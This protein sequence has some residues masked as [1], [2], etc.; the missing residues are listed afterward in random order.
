MN[1]IILSS[2]LFG[3][4]HP[5]S[6]IILGQ[7]IELIDFCLLYVGLR[8]IFQTPFFIKNS[9]LTSN[10]KSYPWGL[11]VLFGFVGAALQLSEFFGLSKGL[12][13]ATVTFLVY[14]HP[15]WS[16]IL[17]YFINKEKIGANEVIRVFI[18]IA[19]IYF[20][21]A[22]AIESGIPFDLRIIAPIF[23]GFLI[24]LWSSL[25]NKLRKLGLA[26]LDV[27]F[28]Y[29]L[30]A[31]CSLLLLA[32]YDSSIQVHA[33][34]IYKWL[35]IIPNI[36]SISFYSIAIGL[37]PNFLFYLGSGRSS[38]LN[39]SLLLLIEPV[40]ATI[41]AFLHMS[42]S[43]SS[44]FFAGALFV[45]LS[46]LPFI[47]LYSLLNK[48]FTKLVKL[49]LFIL[50]ILFF[51]PLLLF[52][53]KLYLVE[54]SPQNQMEY[55]ISEELRLIETS[56][57]MSIQK[58]KQIFPKCKL[59]VV[60]HLELGSEE[61]LFKYANSIEGSNEQVAIV[62][63]SRSTFARIGA[64]ALQGRNILGISIG[65]TAAHFNELNPNF[66]SVVSP[67]KSQVEAIKRESLILKCKSVTGFFDIK[68]PLSAEYKNKFKDIFKSNSKSVEFDSEN[69]SPL[70]SKLDSCIFVGLNFA[71]SS[72]ILKQ[73]NE[74]KEVAH[75][76]GTGDWSIHATELKKNLS[77]K[78]PNSKSKKIHTPTG[79]LSNINK[80]SLEYSSQIRNKFKLSPN[81][82]GA[83][84]Y[85]AILIAAESLCENKSV[86]KVVNSGASKVFYLRPYSA[87][88]TSQNLIS[89][90]NMIHFGGTP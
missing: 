24:A 40:I 26:S 38:N 59:D 67:L 86:D 75:I 23:A 35:Y 81:P 52:A 8:L 25:S 7:G 29:D 68:D 18:G 15:V 41:I 63:L 54:V 14:S 30:F 1:W 77:G 39:A 74:A 89:K 43:V 12:P 83:Y 72:Q 3:F 36:I 32:A 80:T 61:D 66:F 22:Q 19:G 48:Q 45:L 44:L 62:G 56:A 73:L 78:L 84:T 46:G 6:K 70:S 90:M 47:D 58:V 53:H 31:F 17:S 34:H 16:L 64:K 76:F 87:I 57:D 88:S 71:K 13:V 42:E 4:V 79:W 2:V 85:D 33:Q 27:S 28:F 51:T 10:S 49:N 69:P 50:F 5:G 82:I 21:S 60:K 20:I 11:L 65:A 55:T 37:F 9:K